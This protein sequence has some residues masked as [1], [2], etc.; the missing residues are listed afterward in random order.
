M[1]TGIINYR[2]ERCLTVALPIVLGITT[3]SPLKH[4]R[5]GP[6][7]K[8]AVV[9]M[10]GLGH[11]AVQ[12]AHARGADVTVLSQTL[13]KKDDGMRLGADH[14]FATSH[15]NTFQQL[16]GTF[17]LI[18]N[19]VSAGIDISAYLK[20]LPLDGTMV[21]VG[22]PAEPLPV[23]AFALISGRRSFP[24]SSIGG[25]RETQEM[26]DFCAKHGI[27][28]ETELIGANRINE[29]YERVLAS[30]VRDRFVIDA[31]TLA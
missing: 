6:G 31:A 25:I 18:V 10:G 13:S 27:T 23:S 4:W 17:D 28:P 14:Y 2:N 16:A 9:G 11:M 8:V 30:Q 24:G 29:A 5:A 20:L 12:I 19:T 3:Y 1:I 26:L 21:N 22:A 7:K 15:P